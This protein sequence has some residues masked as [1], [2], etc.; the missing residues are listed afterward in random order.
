MNY[1]PELVGRCILSAEDNEVNQIVLEHTLGEQDLPFVIVS[2]G[3]AAVAAWRE[4]KPLMILMDI[5]MP[6]QNGLD[7]T[8]EIRA[9]ELGTG[10]HVPI[11]AL[12][13]H[14]LKGDEEKCMQAGADY[15]LTKPINPDVLL[16]KV[17]EII[18]QTNSPR[19]AA[20]V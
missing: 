1:D 15:Y 19:I 6:V 5:S 2:D 12:T 17:S 4:L 3:A 14:A 8:R 13:A 9:E 10:R 16:S 7:A 20:I 18:E 11:V